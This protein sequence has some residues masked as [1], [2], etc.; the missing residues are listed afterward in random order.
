MIT[1]IY[2]ASKLL[3][4]M[5]ISSGLT[6]FLLFILIAT[7]S[8]LAVQIYSGETVNITVDKEYAYYSIIGNTSAVS[9]EIN[10]IGNTI[11]ITPNKYS[12]SNTF[13]LIFFDKE[14]EVITVY[15]GGGRSSSST[16][17]V[18]RNVT[19]YVNQTVTEFVNQS[20][21]ID[22]E[23]ETTREEISIWI[24]ILLWATTLVGFFFVYQFVYGLFKRT[25]Q[26][27]SEENYNR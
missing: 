4:F 7:P 19:Q 13:E 25:M 9:L 11:F 16:E 6:I 14:K 21:P 15:R 26:N 20:V 2:K 23:G 18:D 10:Q 8:V 24:M 12:I 27:P 5:K 1:K 22:E 17:Y 3:V